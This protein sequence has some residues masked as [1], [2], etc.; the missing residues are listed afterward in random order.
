MTRARDLPAPTT[1]DE[2]LRQLRDL[3]CH[4]LGSISPDLIAR[5]IIAMTLEADWSVRRAAVEAIARRYQF[6]LRDGLTVTRRP[7]GGP[8]GTYATARRVA[9]RGR[10]RKGHERPY[11]TV[12]SRLD[13]LEGSCDCADFL[14]GSLGVCKHLLTVID[15]LAKKPPSKRAS[16]RLAQAPLETEALTWNPALS[17]TG[18]LDRLTGLRLR[19][20]RGAVPAGWAKPRGP[21]KTRDEL[22]LAPDASALASLDRRVAMLRALSHAKSPPAE[23]AARALVAEELARGERLLDA[24]VA[25]RRAL[26]HLRSL[27]RPLYPYQRAGVTRFLEAGRLLLADDMGLGKT[28]QAV[29]AC[30]ALHRAGAVRRGLLIVPAALKSQWISEWERTTDV[31]ARVVEGTPQ[32]RAKQYRSLRSGFLVIGYEQL[33]KDFDHVQTLAPELVVLDEAQR[34]KNWAT[35]S[36]AYVKALSPRYR[37]VLT[38][39]PMENRLE[40]LASVLDWVDDVALAPKW[41]LEPWHTI[42]SGSGA[43]GARNLDT[44]RARLAPCMLRRV[45]KEVL[46]QLPA[47]TDTRVPVAMTPQQRE[48]HDALSPQIA[49]LSA[50]GRSRP[51]TQAEFL[52]LMQLLTTQRMI[53]NGLGQTRFDA[54]WPAYRVAR[55]DDALLEGLFAPKLIEL[56]RLVLEL[57]VRQERKVVIFSQ[58]RRMLTLAEWSL[59]DVLG[60]AGL[61]AVFFT[62]AES[63]RQRAKG[64]V[65]LHDDPR[66]RVMLL[67]DAGG[68]GLNL[69]RAASACI[70]LEIP[71]NPAVLEQRV[72]R[73]YRIGQKRPIDVYNLASEY[74]IEARIGDLVSNKR[75]LFTGVFDGTSDA[76][77]FEGASSFLADVEKLVAMPPR[78]QDSVASGRAGG[79]A[80][81]VEAGIASAGEGSVGNEANGQEAEGAADSI[82]ATAP[83]ATPVVSG[84]GAYETPRPVLGGIQTRRTR[85]GG[86]VIEASPEAAAPLLAMF[87][88][89]AAM[90]RSVMQTPG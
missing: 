65:E 79:A 85:E 1:L 12:L 18:P 13:P 41:R 20:R 5:K 23:P 66:V 11:A 70:N 71:W 51:L 89:M 88:S 36:A 78:G 25:S 37:L 24:R 62:G 33:L 21:A 26:G 44:L 22:P 67:S 15:T 6:A 61:R 80:W 3:G 43:S 69:Q 39:T 42:D 28:T 30:H 63:P 76:V 74:G 64:I 10:L 68:V 8:L 81:D 52:R 29:A 72:G 55:P 56:R 40:E 82:E 19:T 73:I 60:D 4:R 59:R 32:E 45:R 54:L 14:R 87:E 38:G 77:Q 34:I 53:S 35:K 9:G 46:S 47:R 86:V 75:A 48:E 16:A 7:A 90:L 50:R 83:A 49:A 31:P 27:R 57:A 2:T 84:G 17:I 58:W